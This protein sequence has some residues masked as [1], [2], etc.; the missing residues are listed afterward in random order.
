[1]HW[2]GKANVINLKD[3]WD[4]VHMGQVSEI[5]NQTQIQAM[6]KRHEK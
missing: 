3:I 6:G 2:G 4:R 1:M 5:G